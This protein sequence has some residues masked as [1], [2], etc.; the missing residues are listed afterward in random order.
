MSGATGHETDPT[1]L[2]ESN[3]A[4]GGH[5]SHLLR[6]VEEAWA[7]V[8]RLEAALREAERHCDNWRA[9]ADARAAK[10][11]S[12]EGLLVRSEAALAT[13]RGGSRNGCP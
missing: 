4:L 1:K 9:E 11:I 3:L 10:L 12:S 5:V 6:D 8:A 7:E 2:L 13:L